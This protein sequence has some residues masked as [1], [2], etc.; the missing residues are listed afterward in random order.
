MT[1]AGLRY[2]LCAVV[3]AERGLLRCLETVSD[4]HADE[5]E[6][7]H[8]SRTL[9]AW[10]Q[11]HIGR[12]SQLAAAR[13][14]D[15]AAPDGESPQQRPSAGCAAVGVSRTP[16]MELLEDLRW[17]YLSAADASTAWEL[18]AQQAQAT[19]DGELLGVVT[20]CHP[21]TLRQLRWANT[22]LKAASPQALSSMR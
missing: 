11:T 12:I 13:S 6:V 16:G 18:V 20:A 4:R 10:S 17:A 9:R 2:A 14:I 3:A 1:E 22:M 19:R 15:V 5:H 8:V 7:Y 21:Q